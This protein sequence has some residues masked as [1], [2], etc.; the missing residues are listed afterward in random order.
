MLF[1][2]SERVKYVIFVCLLLATATVDNNSS[3][4]M[5][6]YSRPNDIPPT[7][8]DVFV[9]FRGPDVRKDFLAHL[10][11]EFSRK[12]IDA[13]VD[14]KLPKGDEQSEALLDAIEGSLISVIIF[15]QNYSSSSWCLLELAKIVECRKKDGQVVLPIFYKVDPSHVRHQKGTFGDAFA[16]HESKYSLTTIQTWRSALNE[17]ANIAGFHS[18]NY[19]DEAELV[20]EIVK[21]VSMRLKNVHQVNSK[22]LVGI[23]KRIADVESLLQLEATDVRIIGI[24]GMGGI[25]EEDL[26]IDTP[27]GLPQ[28]VE[29]RLRRMKV[30]IILDDV[31]DSEQLEILAGTHD[32]FGS[33]SRIVITTRDKQVLAKEFAKI[34]KV[35]ALTIDESLQLFKLNAFKQ[36]YL[37]IESYD[38]LS[39]KVVKYANGI[40]LVLKVLGHHLHGKDREI[41]ESQLTKVQDKKVHDII[42]LSYN[43]LDQ[44]E[45]KIFLDIA[46]FFDGLN[47]KV[48]Y[49][50]F[51]L[52]D[53]GY[54][55]VAGL[56]RLKDKDL[57]R[58]SQENIVSMHNI[59]QETGWQIARQESIEDPRSQRRLLDPYQ[60]LKNNEGNEAIRSI[61]INLSRM[62]QLQL[63][64]EVFTKMSKLYFLDLYS[65]GSCSTFLQDQ[66]GLS[67]PQGL[68]SLPNELR[69]LRWT[70]YPLEYLPS[71]FSAQN[72]VEL[73]LPYSRLKKLWQEAPDLVNLKVLILHS[74]TQLKK[75]PNFSRSTD[76][77]SID[78]RFCI[79]LTS[80][81][82]SVFSL[83]KLEK[84]DLGGCIS[85]RRLRSSIHLDS[86]RYLS[87]Y[88]C[89]S[90]KDF[91]VTSK[92][93]VKLNLELTSIKQL[94]SS[95]G[96]Q[97]KLQKLRLAY[98]YIENLPGSIKYLSRLRHL[99][100]RQCI[101]LRTLPE[102]PSSLETLDA[103][104]CVSLETV[105]FPSAIEQL[106]ENKKRVAFWNCLKLDE[107]SLRAIE[108]NAQINMMKFAHQHLSTFGDVQGTYVYPGSK[109]PEWLVHKTT[110]DYVTIDHSFVLTPHSSHLGFIFCFIVPEFPYEGLVLEFKINEDE[111][112]GK[113]INVYLD[114][115]RRGIKLDH[116]YLM[117]DQACSRYLTSLAKHQPRLKIKV[118]VASRTLTSKY[119][120]LQLKG[121]GVTIINSAQY[122]SFV[123]KLEEGDT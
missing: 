21:S 114:R 92:N 37:E 28:Y 105:M 61:V 79:G 70:H 80:I 59:I 98:T 117:Y 103:R 43:D 38:E 57:I 101:E 26:K 45:K 24:W 107:H 1:R 123:Q 82:P 29:R 91:S 30:L 5:T 4:P 51:L 31:N 113:N 20:E 42:K 65:K 100:L 121:F 115:P 32:W 60:V 90:L 17:S 74:S 77:K 106:K 81:H 76:L 9:S 27:N 18:S 35:E 72:L 112:E 49:I 10:T 111:G 58:V 97:S 56:E 47:L 48:K 55:V 119:I 120:P 25:G 11:K 88:G 2:V 73:N 93:M 69:Y 94:P 13:F 41:W 64:P 6:S 63:N 95:I 34:Y 12:Q 83:K 116:V 78:L 86:L 68:E 50:N 62:E 99:D 46:C 3:Y 39:K 71:K 110:R 84:L 87:L 7:K 23:G 85:L 104:G 122:H 22:G 40:P 44:D 8:Y 96:L 108:M 89:I 52:K 67:L 75:L 66:G 33:G 16:Q 118:T 109:I 102:L 53:H 14:Y 36:N 15:S 54:P 19:R